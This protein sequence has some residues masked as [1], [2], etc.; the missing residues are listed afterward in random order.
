MVIFCL[1]GSLLSLGKEKKS[2]KSLVKSVGNKVSTLPGRGKKKGR[3]DAF[4]AIPEQTTFNSKNK[5]L[6]KHDADPGVLSD[7]EDEFHF[8]EL[9]HKSSHSSLAISQRDGSLENLGGGEFL[10]RNY[11]TPPPPQ[12][13]KSTS[14][15]DKEI[16]SGSNAGFAADSFDDWEAKLFG[17]Q[18]NNR[19]NLKLLLESI[20]V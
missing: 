18:N 9:S 1:G 14:T 13:L 2:L 12:Q 8:D 19:C 4:G 11:A 20:Y 10:R 3:D 15:M 17:K 7:E 16:V 6:N 5:K